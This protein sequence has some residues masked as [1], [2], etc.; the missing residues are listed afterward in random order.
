MDG[1]NPEHLSAAEETVRRLPSIRDVHARGRSMGRSLI[2]DVEGALDGNISL[3][4]ANFMARQV[5]E[6]VHAAVEDGSRG[7]LDST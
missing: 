4:N 2:L 1:V 7:M 6:A 5:E 3:T